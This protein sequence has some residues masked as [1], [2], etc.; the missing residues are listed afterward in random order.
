MAVGV[1]L[2]FAGGALPF[3]QWAKWAAN[4]VLL[5]AYIGFWFTWEKVKV[6]KSFKFF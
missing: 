5:I 2:Y 1:A 3:T 4:T 6:G